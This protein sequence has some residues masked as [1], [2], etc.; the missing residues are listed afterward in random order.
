MRFAWRPWMFA[1]ICAV[2]ST[3]SA[4][5]MHRDM[6]AF[7]RANFPDTEPGASVIV[8]KDGKVLFRRAYGLADVELKVRSDPSM[9]YCIGSLTKQF[10]AVAILK[11]V[12]EGKISLSE[13][14]RA[15]LPDYPK[16][17]PR[18]TIEQL[19]NQTS[20][21][22]NF[23]ELSTWRQTMQK[24]LD[25]DRLIDFF[26][27][28]PLD[29]MPGDAWHYS[30][31]NYVLLGAVIERVSGLRYG[32]FMRTKLFL[33]LGMKHTVYA[34]GGEIVQGSMRGYARRL[35][36]L[37]DAQYVST[38]Q[39]YSAAG[40]RS[41][42]DDLALWNTSLE[43]GKV[44]PLTL[45]NKAWT[46]GRLNDG[47]ATGYGFGWAIW[48]WQNRK[49]VGHDGNIFGFL[50][51]MVRVP[52][53]NLFVAVLANSTNSTVSPNDISMKLAALAL[54][55]EPA[56]P[57]RIP[58]ANEIMDRYVGSYR[59]GKSEN[60]RVRRVGDQLELQR[61]DDEWDKVFAIGRDTFLV[62]KSHDRV[63]FVD[64]LSGRSSKIV[65]EGNFSGIERATRI[66]ATD[67]DLK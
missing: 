21:V 24:E 9:V 37:V 35:G 42:V 46:S 56:Q 31:S 59:G 11:L 60:W 64:I 66:V 50:S 40:V 49:V 54:G 29:F 12:S 28:F 55:I 15:Y 32:D 7:L 26:K 20:G 30:N 18:V 45:M 2:S 16:V 63:T 23:V 10:T 52:S 34:E 43:S 65:V 61:N 13:D 48:Q 25:L 5:A 17:G 33:P 1:L 57:K 6:D 36:R 27:A 38:T 39:L 62:E 3:A 47:T 14:F 44:I 58:V 4:R 8:V 53:D 22:K 19:L 67:T 51:S 41:S